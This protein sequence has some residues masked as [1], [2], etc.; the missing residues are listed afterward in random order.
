MRI[1]SNLGLLLYLRSYPLPPISFFIGL[2]PRYRQV[3]PR[4][5]RYFL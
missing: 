1:V 2:V 5:S 4:S 3:C